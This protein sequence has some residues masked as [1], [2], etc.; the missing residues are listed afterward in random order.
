MFYCDN[1]DVSK[2]EFDAAWEA[3][4]PAEKQVSPITP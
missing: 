1:H 3:L 4:E 2:H